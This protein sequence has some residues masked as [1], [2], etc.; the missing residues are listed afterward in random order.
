MTPECLWIPP[1]PQT[2]VFFFF[3]TLWLKGWVAGDIAVRGQSCL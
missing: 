1:T 2:A 3:L